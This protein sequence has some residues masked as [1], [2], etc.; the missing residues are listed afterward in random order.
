MA[1]KKKID[2]TN[3]AN[4]ELQ[5]LNFGLIMKAFKKNT[6]LSKH[7]D[8]VYLKMN[9]TLMSGNRPKKTDSEGGVNRSVSHQTSVQAEEASNGNIGNYSDNDFF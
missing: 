5:N 1:A 8:T 7:N 3:P 6:V 2:Y 9:R 4:F